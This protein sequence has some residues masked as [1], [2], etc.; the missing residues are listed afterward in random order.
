MQNFDE[1]HFN[2]QTCRRDSRII[3]PVTGGDVGPSVKPTVEPKAVV[4]VIPPQIL[5]IHKSEVVKRNDQ[6]LLC[7]KSIFIKSDQK[8]DKNCLQFIQKLD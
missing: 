3:I 5:D 4:V 6:A 2:K 8:N 7:Q 1:Q